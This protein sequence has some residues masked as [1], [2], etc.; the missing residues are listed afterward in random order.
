MIKRLIEDDFADIRNECN[1]W[2]HQGDEPAMIMFI[3]RRGFYGYEQMTDNELKKEY[4][5]RFED[6]EAK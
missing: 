1:A 6:G 4:R 5:N 3:L 2:E